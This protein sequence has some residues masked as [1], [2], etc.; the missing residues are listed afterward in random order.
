MDRLLFRSTLAAAFCFSL[1]AQILP[2]AALKQPLRQFRTL[3]GNGVSYHGGPVMT[4]GVNLYYIWYGNWSAESE[5][6]GILTALAQGIGGSAYFN[7]NS[8]YRGILDG[9]NMPVENMVR[10][11]GSAEDNYSQGANLTSDSTLAIVEAAIAT[12][13]LPADPNGIYFVLGSPDTTESGF[14]K[15]G[16]GWHGWGTLVNGKLH[17][18]QFVPGGMD[19]KYAFVGN[20]K[21]QCIRFCS[22]YS[23]NFP[24]PNG[25]A[26]GDAMTS[27]IAH[28]MSEVASDPHVNAWFDSQGAENADKCQ[29][30]F[31]TIHRV[32]AG[33]PHANGVYN[34]TFG[35]RN[36][37]LQ[38]NW[39]NAGGGYCAVGY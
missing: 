8:T 22:L 1:Q 31:G 29:W 7:I 35:G 39:V 9:R 30:T 3:A 32:P 25:N 6:A 23:A 34:V 20:P 5:A 28:E 21:T 13:K 15:T 18:N 24:P 36:F 38:Q 10:Y 37:L 17:P 4:F 19:I 2:D 14:C 12:G 33:Q 16:C 27:I 26:A 11:A